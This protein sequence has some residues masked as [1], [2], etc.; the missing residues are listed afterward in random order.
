MHSKNNICSCIA[1]LL[2]MF[3]L[4]AVTIFPSFAADKNCTLTLICSSDSKPIENLEW[5]VYRIGS[6]N[7]SGGFT[8]EGDFRKYP[9]SFDDMSASSVQRDAYTLENYAI[10]DGVPADATGKT[11][12]KGRLVLSN[13][14]SGIYLI[15][16]KEYSTSKYRFIP[17][18]SIVE[19][20]EKN[21]AKTVYPK[22]R[23]EEIP[24][25]KKVSYSLRKVWSNDEGM[26]AVRPK[27]IS[28]ELYANEKLK[29]TIKLNASNGWY[30]EWESEDTI[31]WR[32]KEKVVAKGYTVNVVKNDTQFLIVNTYNPPEKTTSNTSKTVTK[33]KTKTVTKTKTKTITSE[34]TTVTTTVTTLP[35]KEELKRRIEEYEE[36]P[37]D[38]YTP[39]SWKRFK[40]ALE[41]AK[42]TLSYIDST[43]E[44][45]KKALEE[46]ENAKNH[47]VLSYEPW[48]PQTGQL[49]WP[50]PILAGA[51]LVL[52][53]V[54][55][56]IIAKKGSKN[57]KE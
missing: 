41:R 49:W 38:D 15:T 3:M 24:E 46:L 43:D 36:F 44:E 57:D 5:S 51:G 9:V 47:L 6:R 30:Y 31:S 12:K 50:V 37:E 48:L 55:V 35:P 29:K 27:E 54:G 25:K 56:R 34:P 14:K 7:S 8:L 45:I 21:E 33:T 28:V 18:S 22:F 40:E 4:V 20:K 17:S 13:L 53:A 11:D 52:I 42:R 19:L 16:G 2:M 23:I 39:E 26:S 10:L 1:V 32:V